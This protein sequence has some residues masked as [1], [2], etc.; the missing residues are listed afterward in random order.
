MKSVAA[1]V[2]RFATATLALAVGACGTTA[3]RGTPADA[4]S[5]EAAAGQAAET[6]GPPMQLRAGQIIVALPGVDADTVDARGARLAERYDITYVRAFPL[7]SIDVDCAVFTIADATRLGR[8][9]DALE[10]DPDVVLA[11]PNVG[12]RTLASRYNDPYASYQSHLETLGAESV[13]HWSTGENVTVAVIDTGI[14]ATHPDFAERI[15][16]TENFVQ[17][18][19]ESF[20]SDQHGTAEEAVVAPGADRTM[21]VV[22]TPTCGCCGAWVELARREGY[23]VE[24]TDTTDYV[25]MKEAASVPEDVWSCHT[26]R[27]GGYTVEGHV[28][29]AAVAKL[30][31]ERPDIEGIAVPGMP[32][33]SPGMGDDPAARYDVI[34]YGG[35]A[36]EGEVFFRAGIDGAGV[37]AGNPGFLGRLFGRG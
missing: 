21:H 29:F 4:P 23:D 16:A 10:R 12:F 26:T 25:G 7:S 35:T 3:F 37:P 19:E 2:L 32:A 22:K 24:V 1:R 20:A 13:H 31:A 33:G 28:P 17:G 6:A 27:I 9:L 36:G 8:V 18:G 15:V 5:T 11:Q 14:D 34:A 30:L